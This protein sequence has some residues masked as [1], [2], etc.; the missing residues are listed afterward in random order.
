VCLSV[1]DNV[2]MSEVTALILSVGGNNCKKTLRKVMSAE[3]RFH[4]DVL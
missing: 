3:D 4:K 2:R 1:S